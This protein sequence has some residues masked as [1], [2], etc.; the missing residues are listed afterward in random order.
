LS[1]VAVIFNPMRK[2]LDYLIITIGVSILSLGLALFLIPHKIAAGGISG[3]GII[4]FYLFGINVGYTIFFLN[5]I[6]FVLG[7]RILGRSFG[8]KTIYATLAYSAIV[9]VLSRILPPE[10]VTDDMI[11]NVLFGCFLSGAGMAIVF[12]REA[13]TGGTDIIA[14]ILKKLVNLD[15]SWGLLIVDFTITLFAGVFFG[16]DI[17]MYALL[18]VIVNTFTIDTVLAGVT[19]SI[20]VMIISDRYE[21]IK[22][23]ILNDVRRGAT[24]LHGEGAFTGKD[25]KIILTVLRRKEFV[26]LKGIVKEED[27]DAFLLVSHVR[28]VLGEGFKPIE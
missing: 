24:L 16:K 12:S 26:R 11:L 3:V 18:G 7:F 19:T 13:S 4:L 1:L 2:F 21:R 14:M 27:P 23:R 20:Q 8:F 17:G 10:G 9:A 5:L 25:R 28:E 6:L 22:E 15:V